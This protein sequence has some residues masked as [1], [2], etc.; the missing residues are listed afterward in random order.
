MWRSVQT[1][2]RNR[3][4]ET[5]MAAGTKQ[6]MCRLGNRLW[7]C[8]T[9]SFRTSVLFSTRS[10]AQ[11]DLESLGVSLPKGSENWQPYRRPELEAWVTEFA[12]GKRLG[13]VKLS[14]FVFGQS[15][16]LD[17]MQRVVVWQRAK[18]RAGTA[19]TKA[20]WEVRGGGRKPHPQKGTG[21]ARQ[22]SIRAP[23]MRGGGV[24]HGPRPRSYYYTLPR[25]VRAQ[26]VRCALSVKYAQGDLIVVDSLSLQLH[27]TQ[28][29]VKILKKHKLE[30]VLLVDGGP[31]DKNLAL[32]S[33]NLQEVDVLPS[34]GL[35]TY[36][37][38]L[39]KKLVLSLGA[40]RMLE[41]R[42]SRWQ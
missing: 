4:E 12:T 6:L 42:L 20:W 32:A 2:L 8:I 30:S 28:R 11:E 1:K 19:K 13:I 3:H 40:V 25:Q 10:E 37:I 23:H 26:G 21:R 27:K 24:V 5:K 41:E 35:N 18:I 14:N 34:V 39:R 31:L 16:R 29:L 33:S 22:G 38:L 9:P 17:I 36:S 7:P 15:P